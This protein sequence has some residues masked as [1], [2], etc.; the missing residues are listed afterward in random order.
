[1]CYVEKPYPNMGPPRNDAIQSWGCLP[2]HGLLMEEHEQDFRTKPWFTN[3][4]FIT[5]QLFN[6]TNEVKPYSIGGC[7]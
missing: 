5:P 2:V 3:D 4:I 7:S 1:M 6:C